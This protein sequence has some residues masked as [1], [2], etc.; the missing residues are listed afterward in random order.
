MYVPPLLKSAPCSAIPYSHYAINVN[1]NHLA[2][3]TSEDTCFGHKTRITLQCFFFFRTPKSSAALSLHVN[4]S[5]EQHWTDC[6]TICRL[7]PVLHSL[8]H[9]STLNP[10]IHSKVT[11]PRTW[12]AVNLS[13]F[14]PHCV[15]ACQSACLTTFFQYKSIY[16][17]HSFLEKRKRKEDAVDI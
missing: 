6:R 12:L 9:I 2:W 5:P 15:Y 10:S 7:S 17:T 13:H 1:L 8:P 16:F 11:D 3:I 14:Y 4:L